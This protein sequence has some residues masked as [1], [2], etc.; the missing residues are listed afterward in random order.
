MNLDKRLLRQARESF[1]ALILTIALGFGVGVLTVAQASALSRVIDRVFLGG[2]SLDDVSVLLAFLLGIILLRAC[3]TWG[4]EVAANAI[5]VRVKTGLRRAL[6]QRFLALGPAYTREERTGELVNAAV[7]GIEDLDAYFSQ[8][9]PGLVLAALVP[10]TVLVFVFPVDPL[11]GV[12][13]LLTAPLI[14]VF[15]ILIGSAAQALTRR[16][17]GALSRMSAYFLDVLQGLTALK[18]LGRSRVQT[19]VI[20]DVS[21]RFRQTTMSVLRVT[22]LSA[23]VLEM[24]STLSTAVV[25]VEVGLRLLYGR[26]P[27][28]QAFL[29]LLLAPE[30]YLPLRLLGTRFHAGMSGV[31]AAKR[32]FEILEV[33]AEELGPQAN[34]ESPM[35]MAPLESPPA[36]RPSSIDHRHWSA[37]VN[38]PRLDI[39]L[40]DLHFSYPDER[41]ALKGVTFRIPVGCKVALVGP[42][43]GGKSTLASLLLRF[44][45]PTQG[46]IFVGD[47]PVDEIPPAE[48]RSLVAWVPQNPF[49]FNDTVAANIRL[50]RPEASL[51][52][53]VRAAEQAHAHEF[54]QDLPQGYDTRVGERGVRLSGGQAQR[55]ALAR[56][57]LKDAPLVILDEATANLDPEHEDRLGESLA[58]LLEGRTALIIAHRLNTARMSDRII[59]LDQG[60]VVESGTHV[61]LLGVGGL[62]HDLAQAFADDLGLGPAAPERD[63]SIFPS[64][65]P[66]PTPP[67]P[68]SLAPSPLPSPAS[69]PSSPSASLHT[70]RRLFKLV[71]PFTG[72]VAISVLVGVLTVLS[73]IGLM[74]TSAYI[75]SAAALGPSIAELQ[76]AIVGVR[77][78]GIT[79]GLFRYLERYLSHQTT[80]RL[81]ARLRVWFYQALEPL[82]PARLMSYRSGDLLGR[83]LGDIESLEGFYVRA[84]APPLVAVLVALAGC[85]F[86]ARFDPRLGWVL[87]FFLVVAG[88]GVPLLARSLS[89]DAARQLVAQ[90]AALNAALVDTIQGMADLVAFDQGARQVSGIETLNQALGRTQRRLA[91]MDGLQGALS[92][93]LASLGVWAVLLLAI[94]QVHGGG[95]QGVYL[96]VLALA[97]L[98]SFEAVSPLPL[99][100]QYLE[101][102]LQAA[103]RLFELVAAPPEVV[104]PPETLHLPLDFGLRIENLRFRYPPLSH[105]PSPASSFDETFRDAPWA[106]DAVSFDLPPGKR[107]AIVGPSGAGKT[108]LVN[109]LLRFWDYHEGLILLNRRDLRLYAQEHLRRSIGVVPQ[110][111][112]LFSASVRDNL[113]IAHPGASQEEIVWAAERAQL[114]AFIQSL[115]E[116]Y[117]TWIGEHG[118]RLSAGQRQRLALARVLLKDPALLI[119]DEATANLDALTERRVLGA[120]Y[121][122]M[123]GRTTLVCTHRLVGMGTMDEILVLDRGRVIERGR[124]TELLEVDGLYRRMWDLQNQVLLA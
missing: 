75:I 4:G 32:L 18:T 64:S 63:R 53:V 107:L 118:Q 41:P 62:Y 92:G 109:L 101:S 124:H 114:H 115:P 23:L 68:S 39:R 31:A 26:L 88:L 35:T 122:L 42:S 61:Q 117:D 36:P 17:W 78:F 102:N 1:G 84:L 28:E 79:R 47:Q 33:P 58:R 55:I 82:A 48:W 7:G 45:R 87:A 2:R 71:T 30:F 15:M 13:L 5:A 113:R 81:L 104:D 38:P 77:F 108:T 116:G 103:R 94:P 20:A 65:S 12:V 69:L 16:Q 119:L 120:I 123:E 74:T 121:E 66:P 40:E 85:S 46:A 43:G 110:N 25:A 6:L 112:Y 27:F 89:V 3:L 49:L 29:V 37:D 98:T 21:E 91:T 54:I 8:Y 52:E 70:L 106:L 96:A 97:A 105:S 14:P 19:E 111:T 44:I 51:G 72:W 60:Q 9:L 83:I 100:A 22:F 11:S 67:L 56:A 99:A 59:V 90:R 76:V 73:G 93:L 95:I 10:L 57:F 34:A 80:F 24:V 86:M 50:A